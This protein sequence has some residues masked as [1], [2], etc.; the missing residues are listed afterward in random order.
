MDVHEHTKVE[1]TILSDLVNDHADS[2]LHFVNERWNE[3]VDFV[4]TILYALHT[5]ATDSWWWLVFVTLVTTLQWLSLAFN[6]SVYFE[7]N[8]SDSLAWLFAATK[9]TAGFTTTNLA[10]LYTA[11]VWQVVIVG[12]GVAA[13]MTSQ[14]LNWVWPM[15]VFRWVIKLTST[16]L[17]FPIMSALLHLC[18][19]CLSVGSSNPNVYYTAFTCNS[20]GFFITYLLTLI[21]ICFFL[22]V[23]LITVSCF[24][25]INPY[26]RPERGDCLSVTSRAHGLDAILDIASRF[27]LLLFFTCFSQFNDAKWPLSI[28]FL[29]M[30]ATNLVVGFVWLPIFDIRAQTL[31]LAGHTIAFWSAIC[32]VIANSLG[33]D[34]HQTYLLFL[35]GV[36]M[37]VML[38]ILSIRSRIDLLLNWTPEHLTSS[39]HVE[40]KARLMIRQKITQLGLDEPWSSPTVADAADPALTSLF[41]DV[42]KLYDVGLRRF[43]RDPYMHFHVSCYY[44]YNKLNR[45]M[46]YRQLKVVA[47][48]PRRLDLGFFVFLIRARSKNLVVTETVDDAPD[49]GQ[50]AHQI[51]MARALSGAA[52]VASVQLYIEFRSRRSAADAASR[53]AA[54]SYLD[55][56]TELMRASPDVDRILRYST[57]GRQAI[58]L[59]HS[60]FEKLLRINAQSVPVL[61]AYGGF[62]LDM[63][64]DIKTSSA[65]LHRADEVEDQRALITSDV[66]ELRFNSNQKNSLDIYDERNALVS[67][68]IDE[69][70]FSLIMGCNS[71]ARDMYG[72]NSASEMIGKNINVII[73]EPLASIHNDLVRRFLHRNTS[74]LLNRTRLIMAVH[75]KGYLVPISLNARWADNEASKFV[76]VMSPVRAD[77]ETVIFDRDTDRVTYVQ[78]LLP[79]STYFL[80]FCNFTMSYSF[81]GDPL[82]P[83]LSSLVLF[84]TFIFTFFQ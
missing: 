48:L 77:D 75:R 54:Q 6:D 21:S 63:H 76:G 56:W 65:L 57:V 23:S 72:Y 67:M 78:L 27:L 79:C 17:F 73:P 18:L 19:G 82:F 43:P 39:R 80:C 45:P 58:L 3:A 33:S 28:A 81:L 14:R 62:I 30:T 61:R 74:T 9:W 12:T 26:Q 34:G 51:A 2:F 59:A 60:N 24:Y 83:F 22:L 10:G 32:V 16:I 68:S 41:T 66:T 11:I 1:G 46:A 31:V 4:Y 15:T 42:E 7:M 37:A 64:G 47:S 84:V 36:P 44:Y 20:V 25:D 69:D 70:T 49:A 40:L 29:I 35:T 55:F 50:S 38:L 5:D 53:L 8:S 52:S 71:S 13:M